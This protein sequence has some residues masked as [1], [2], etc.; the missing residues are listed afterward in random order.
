[1]ACVTRAGY[2]STDTLAHLCPP[3]SLG[4]MLAYPDSQA[5]LMHVSHQNCPPGHRGACVMPANKKY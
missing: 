1:M 3:S 5:A 4:V 2:V